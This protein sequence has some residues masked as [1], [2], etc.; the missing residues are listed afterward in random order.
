MF[1]I[2]TIKIKIKSVS[3][4]NDADFML[5]YKCKIAIKPKNTNN[6]KPKRYK[7]S[8]RRV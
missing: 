5:I 4:C 6:I 1:D 7:C 3:G 8:E 2:L